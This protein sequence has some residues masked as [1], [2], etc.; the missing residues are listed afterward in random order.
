MKYDENGRNGKKAIS[1]VIYDWIKVKFRQEPFINIKL[2]LFF[3]FSINAL[4]I[5]KILYFLLKVN[6]IK[7]KMK[8]Y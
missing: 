5:E 6:N 3:V 2:F 1:S 4:S 7:T 8:N